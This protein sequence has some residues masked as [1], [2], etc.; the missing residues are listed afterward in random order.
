MKAYWIALYKNI[1]SQENIKKYAK[2]VT[3]VL[4]SYG[5]KPI[6]RGGK[7]LTLEGE[8][9]PRTVIWEFPNYEQA[10]KCHD[11]KEYQDGWALAKDTTKRNLQIIEGF[12]T[13]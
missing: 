4:R 13:E 1:D 2:E 9:Y 3:E 5:A 12:S 10:I 6:V 8:K 7:F 11:S